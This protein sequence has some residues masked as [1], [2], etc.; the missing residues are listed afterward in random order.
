MIFDELA[1]VTVY[2]C[3]EGKVCISQNTTSFGVLFIYLFIY[4]NVMTCF[5]PYSRPPLGH[6]MNSF[7]EIV[8]YNL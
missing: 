6:K 3:N 8:Q 2:L 7:E 5:G 4:S 1:C